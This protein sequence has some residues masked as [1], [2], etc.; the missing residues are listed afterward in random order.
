MK[1][2]QAC[3]EARSGSQ[4]SGHLDA[5]SLG[6]AENGGGQWAEEEPRAGRRMGN[7]GLI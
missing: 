5:G 4:T 7:S 6:V 1:G 3:D 2:Y